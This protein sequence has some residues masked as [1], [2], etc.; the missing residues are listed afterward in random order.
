MLENNKNLRPLDILAC[1]SAIKPSFE[2]QIG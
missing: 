2:N 1:N